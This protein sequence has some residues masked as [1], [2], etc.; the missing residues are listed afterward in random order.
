MLITFTTDYTQ[1]ILPVTGYASNGGAH[2][3]YLPV[4][5][6]EDQVEYPDEY[7][8]LDTC[9]I[10]VSTDGVFLVLAWD[11]QSTWLRKGVTN[12][13]FNVQYP[14][15]FPSNFVGYPQ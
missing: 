13:Q 9:F 5:V 1:L 7:P 12:L 8:S 4:E 2:I 6:V 14:V 11:A 3:Y 10:E 15:P